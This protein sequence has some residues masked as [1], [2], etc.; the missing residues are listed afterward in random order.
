MF[1]EKPVNKSVGPYVVHQNG[2]VLI[3]NTRDRFANASIDLGKAY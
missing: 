2:K 1:R 3:L